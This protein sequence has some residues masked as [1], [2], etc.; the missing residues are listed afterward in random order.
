MQYPARIL[1]AAMQ[2]GTLAQHSCQRT[3]TVLTHCNAGALACSSWGTA[4][5]VIRSAVKAGQT[6]QGYC[7][8]DTPAPPGGPP[9]GLGTG[10]GRD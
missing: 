7:L 2:L 10:T 5:G 1:P 4:L 3:V 8:R 6:G 9:H